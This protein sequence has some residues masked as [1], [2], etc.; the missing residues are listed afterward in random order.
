MSCSI[1]SSFPPQHAAMLD[2]LASLSLPDPHMSLLQPSIRLGK[3]GRRTQRQILND[4]QV[5]SMFKGTQDS[6][7]T[8]DPA[9]S[10]PG[11]VSALVGTA[12]G[13]KNRNRR[14]LKIEKLLLDPKPKDSG[15]SG[16]PEV[17]SSESESEQEQEAEECLDSGGQSE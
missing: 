7:L 4:A 3:A 16:L 2:S 10:S 6:T 17:Y 5:Q 14:K 15:I 8:S 13:R 12:W 11:Y 9:L 1:S